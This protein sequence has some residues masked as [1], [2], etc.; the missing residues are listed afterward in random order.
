MN[1]VRGSAKNISILNL[2]RIILMNRRHG[3]RKEGK[4]MAMKKKI[5][6]LFPGIGY[7]TDKPLLYYSKKLAR[8]RGY[9]IIEVKYGTLPSNVKGN[10]K[11][12]L[13][14]FQKALKYATEQLV[15]IQFDA[16]DEVLFLSKSVGTAVAANYA[17]NNRLKVRQVYYTPVVESFDAIGQEGIVFHGT[18]DPWADTEQIK[19]ECKKRNLLLYLTEN[20]NHSM[21]TGNVEQDLVIMKDIM[22]KTAEYMDREG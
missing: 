5:A 2:L 11:R 15:G 9:E 10:S 20:A 22:R 3:L 17:K 19:K 12:M 7:H 16:Y 18:S 6:V 1:E 8:Q 4:Y 13:E 14:A 21:E